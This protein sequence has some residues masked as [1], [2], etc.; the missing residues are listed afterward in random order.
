MKDDANT[1]TRMTATAIKDPGFVNLAC[2]DPDHHAVDGEES[3]VPCLFS[4]DISGSGTED[5]YKESRP[6][7][8]QHHMQA[9]QDDPWQQRQC[10]HRL[11]SMPARLWR[12]SPHLE[13]MP[14]GD[15]EGESEG[16][17]KRP[18]TNNSTASSTLLPQ[19]ASER[20]SAPEASTRQA[21]SVPGQTCIHSF[22]GVALL[23]AA[24]SAMPQA[25][26]AAHSPASSTDAVQ[27]LAKLSSTDTAGALAGA[28]ASLMHGMHAGRSAASML[29]ICTQP[30]MQVATQQEGAEPAGK[31]CS[32]TT[33]TIGKLRNWMQQ[34]PH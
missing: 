29:S 8:R 9:G 14:E 2:S 23:E 19:A 11:A 1:A 12:S 16:S 30:A 24:L 28:H 34:Q 15:E 17:S 31:A 5:V 3:T 27:M 25:P 22:C 13:P 4:I 33:R 20:S 6:G 32:W 21:L 7:I 10:L 26:Q 18:S